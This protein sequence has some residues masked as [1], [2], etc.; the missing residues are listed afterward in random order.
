MSKNKEEQEKA[1]M[2][3]LR[4]I[5]NVKRLAFTVG[6][7]DLVVADIKVGYDL[8]PFGMIEGDSAKRFNYSPGLL[9]EYNCHCPEPIEFPK[10]LH[11]DSWELGILVEGTIH[12]QDYL[13]HHVVNAGE[14]WRI[15]PGRLIYLSSLVILRV[16]I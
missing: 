8:S 13:G 3:A 15:P 9:M 5:H 2:D 1:R 14:M 7:E 10:H 11:K 4:G 12:Y 16:V 6:A